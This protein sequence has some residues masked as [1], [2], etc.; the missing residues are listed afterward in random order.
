M[1]ACQVCIKFRFSFRPTSPRVVEKAIHSE[2][3]SYDGIMIPKL[4]S[5]SPV[6]AVEKVPRLNLIEGN[7]TDGTSEAV[8]VY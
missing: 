8:I 6:T 4:S 1:L 2:K 3:P 5:S 7:S